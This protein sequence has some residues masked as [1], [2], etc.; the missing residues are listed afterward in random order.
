[1]EQRGRKPHSVYEKLHYKYVHLD[2]KRQAAICKFC[3]SIIKNT[4]LRRLKI[5]R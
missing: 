2:N 1:M 5:H 3:N 4:A